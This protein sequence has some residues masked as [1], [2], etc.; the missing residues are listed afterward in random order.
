MEVITKRVLLVLNLY[1]KVD[2]EKVSLEINQV[3]SCQATKI[4]PNEKA[5]VQKYLNPVLYSSFFFFS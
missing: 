4:Y 3:E 1:D 2:N 5:N